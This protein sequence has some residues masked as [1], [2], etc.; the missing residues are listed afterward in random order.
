MIRHARGGG[1]DLDPQLH[2][3]RRRLEPALAQLVRRLAGVCGLGHVRE[4]EECASPHRAGGGGVGDVPQDLERTLRVPG[5]GEVPAEIE[6]PLRQGV[7]LARRREVTRE[8]EELDGS[9]RRAA[10]P[11]G[12]R[13]SR[14]LRRDLVVG[15]SCGERAVT[16][17][18]LGARGPVSDLRVHRAALA[19]S[20]RCVDGRREQRVCEADAAALVD[21]HDPRGLGALQGRSVDRVHGWRGERRRDEECVTG[22][23]GKPPQ[24]GCEE[25]GEVVGNGERRGPVQR[26]SALDERTGQLDREEGISGRRRLDSHERGPRKGATELS[27]ENLVERRKAQRA[28]PEPLGAL[29]GEGTP[30]GGASDPHRREDAHAR[31]DTSARREVEDVTGRRVEP[32]EVVH[33]DENRRLGSE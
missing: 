24:P 23:R 13:S 22:A 16:R 1:E 31:A 12:A 21:S 8:L 7:L 11:R 3:V 25:I 28:E 2:V 26:L 10:I 5:L 6:L 4:Q 19:G 29:V 33:G 9:V 15:L 20:G 30:A 18:F 27:L 14:E 17:A 32:L